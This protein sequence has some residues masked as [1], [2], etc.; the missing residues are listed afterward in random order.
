MP[1]GQL[2]DLSSVR[3]YA[4]FSKPVIYM[5]PFGNSINPTTSASLLWAVNIYQHGINRPVLRGRTLPLLVYLLKEPNSFKTST[6][7]M[8][9]W[10]KQT[11][12]KKKKKQLLGLS[13]SSCSA[14]FSSPPDIRGALWRTSRSRLKNN[15]ISVV[16]SQTSCP[17]TRPDQYCPPVT[18]LRP[19]R[20]SADTE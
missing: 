15:N 6:A 9:I 17:S 4:A 11:N 19:L 7:R 12:K 1:V 5:W 14:S 13:L 2:V 18:A 8:L 16:N 3:M 20:F 10:K